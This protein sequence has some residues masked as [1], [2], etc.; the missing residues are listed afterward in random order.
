MNAGRTPRAARTT[1][2]EIARLAGVSVSTASLVLSGKGSERRI[3]AAVEARVREVAQQKD[4]SPNLLVRSMQG[5]RTHVLTFYNAFLR[6]EVGDLY[7]DRLHTA[8]ERA[9]G[10]FGYD[11]LIHC[12]FRRSEEEIY[13]ALNGGL[14]DGVIF[15]G[16][17]RA[18]PL[19]RL[20]RTSRLPTILIGH[21]DDEGVLS[22]VADDMPDA[23]RQ[24]AD[25]LVELGHRRIAAITG[26][27]NPDAAARI[28]V[29]RTRLAEQGIELPDERIL[30]VHE[31]GGSGLPAPDVAL[32]GLMESPD[33]PTALFCW[34]DRIGYRILEA[35]EELGVSVPEQLS[36]VG[37]D[38]IHWPSISTHFLASIEVPI[39]TFAVDAV[40]I[41]DDLINGVVEGPVIRNVPVAL[42][43]GTTLAPP[44][45]V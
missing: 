11:L 42:N 45:T 34:H 2:K 10:E 25:T 13:R 12:H 33:P 31:E 24:V 38:G 14:T 16:P 44:S 3:S 43:Q 6:R 21:H 4:Y 30:T 15:F 19:L 5:G 35:C 9:A 41:L 1:L 20:L 26:E 37:Y 27:N 28:M 23:M 8:V 7:M 18:S 36:L 40:R 39:P 29:L 22:S 17:H 32:S